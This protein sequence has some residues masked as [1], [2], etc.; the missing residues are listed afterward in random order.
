MALDLMEEEIE[1][2][3]SLLCRIER[4]SVG[5]F[6]WS[7]R[8]MCRAFRKH[9]RWRGLY[10]VPWAMAGA[11]KIR[12]PEEPVW[13]EHASRKFK[14]LAA[15]YRRT[16]KSMGGVEA[17]SL[18]KDL[19]LG[20]GMVQWCRLLPRGD[21]RGMDAQALMEFFKTHV[22][23]SMG[24]HSEDRFELK[25]DT[26]MLLTVYRCMLVQVFEALGMPELAPYLCWTDRIYLGFLEPE[27]RFAHEGTISGGES[28]CVFRFSFDFS[29]PEISR[30]IG[31]P[32]P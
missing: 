3:R 16:A 8:I 32:N 19:I 20:L 24:S 4:S 2:Y 29:E 9:L 23:A 5:R 12:C 27:I 31:A 6:L 1:A 18:A 7:L 10:L 17:E 15:I 30:R 13:I 11:V 14:P 21:A 22:K 25:G 28:R 26:V